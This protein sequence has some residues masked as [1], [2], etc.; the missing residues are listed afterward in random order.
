M[1]KAAIRDPAVA[2]WLEALDWAAFSSPVLKIEELPVLERVA[3]DTVGLYA[4][5][6]EDLVETRPEIVVRA[7]SGVAGRLLVLLF[8]M[9]RGAD[10]VRVVASK[11]EPV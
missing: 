6:V 8:L 9:V 4:V 5:P 7:W 3:V 1:A 11:L 10:W 2:I